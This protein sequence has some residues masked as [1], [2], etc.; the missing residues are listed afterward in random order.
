MRCFIPRHLDKSA[1]PP[2]ILTSCAVIIGALFLSALGTKHRIPLLSTPSVDQ[3]RVS[4]S[5]FY[6]ELIGALKNPNYAFLM[7]GFFL[8]MISIGLDQTLSV[9]TATYFW[10]LA[11]EQIKWFGLVVLP[12]VI[13]GATGSPILMKKFDRKPVLIGALLGVVVFAQLPIDLRLLGLRPAMIPKRQTTSLST[14]PGTASN[15]R[16]TNRSSIIPPTKWPIEL[17]ALQKRREPN[18]LALL[19]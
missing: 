8:L 9:F 13:I 18:R 17:E 15:G 10:E 5:S 1:Y 7:I 11:P 12:G 14:C 4:L 3:T 19:V 6:R 16:T 2:V